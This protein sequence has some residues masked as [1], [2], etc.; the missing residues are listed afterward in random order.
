M[1]LYARTL[2]TRDTPRARA[3]SFS[4]FLFR[5]SF[6]SPLLLYVAIPHSPPHLAF[7]DASFPPRCTHG[8]RLVIFQFPSLAL[9]PFVLLL[10]HGEA[11]EC[12]HQ[13]AA[14]LASF[15]VSPAR[16]DMP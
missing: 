2:L 15:F 14:I 6:H 10:R 1:A 3:Y 12:N 8:A 7:T 13:S 5:F 4:F 16:F 11:F 9:P